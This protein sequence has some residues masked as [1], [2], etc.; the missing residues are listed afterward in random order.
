VGKKE[1][2]AREE[3]GN[4]LFFNKFTDADNEKRDFGRS[5]GYRGLR[6]LVVDS[7]WGASRRRVR[8]VGRGR[9]YP[10]PGSGAGGGN[11]VDD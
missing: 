4:P 8:A 5:C 10:G 2:V 9:G 3:S 11:L 7:V 1:I 6:F